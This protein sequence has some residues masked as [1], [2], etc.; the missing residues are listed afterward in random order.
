MIK[1]NC[2]ECGNELL[3]HPYYMKMYENTFCG[4]LCY[5]A[6]RRSGG[7]DKKGYRVTSINGKKRKE[8]RLVMESYLGRSLLPSEN[9]HHKNGKKQDNRIDNLEVIDHTKHSIEHNQL[10]W[11]LPMSVE[12]RKQGRTLKEV[13]SIVGV[14]RTN[15]TKQLRKAGIK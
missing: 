15:L 11:D 5:S 9:V 7:V 1:T 4:S 14:S 3:R 12:L 10:S 6:Y 13:A 2:A 8:H